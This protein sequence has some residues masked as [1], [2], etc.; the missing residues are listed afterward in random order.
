MA[1]NEATFT[2]RGIDSA[3]DARGIE[4]DLEAV[5]GVM[6]ATVDES[7]EA[8]VRYDADLLAEERVKVTVRDAGYEVD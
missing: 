4:D 7:G 6:G 1:E 5:D 3:D 8:E 2:I